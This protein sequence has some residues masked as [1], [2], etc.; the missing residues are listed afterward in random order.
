MDRTSV[1]LICPGSL[2]NLTIIVPTRGQAQYGIGH[3]K[4]TG[5][6]PLILGA[7]DEDGTPINPQD[8]LL[9]RPGDS[10]TYYHPPSG[11]MQ[12]VAVCVDNCSGG[13]AVLEYDTPIC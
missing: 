3:P 7:L 13:G 12:I 6:C 8:D 2:T 5:D 11:A 10:R 4:N 9:L 1:I